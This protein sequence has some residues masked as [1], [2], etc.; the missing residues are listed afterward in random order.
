MASTTS[1]RNA[2]ATRAAETAPATTTNGGTSKTPTIGDLIDRQRSEIARALP[3]HMDPDRLARIATTVVKTTPK[4]LECTTESLLGALMTSAQTGLEPGPLG[5]AYFVPRWNSKARANEC[6]WQ[7]GYTGIIELARRSGN[8]KSIEARTVYDNDEFEAIYGL[9]DRLH[10]KPLWGNRGTPMLW[11]MVAK[12]LDGGHFWHVMGR[13]EIDAHRARSATPEAG[14]WKSD[15]DAMARKTTIRVAKPY[16]PLSAEIASML[17]HD[18]TV[19]NGI[20]TPDMIAAPPDAITVG[21]IDDSEVT[22]AEVVED[23]PINVDPNTGE[24]QA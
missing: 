6:Q 19:H 3:R 17:D 23:P 15:Y 2:L 13:D 18:E 5:H 11:Y 20:V 1:A 14:P 9:E 21:E 22:D 12:F 4:L 24:V 10:H 7:I 16:L 8:L